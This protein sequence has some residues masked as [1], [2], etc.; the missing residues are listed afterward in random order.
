[1]ELDRRGKGL[2]VIEGSTFV[3]LGA[4]TVTFVVAAAIYRRRLRQWLTGAVFLGGFSWVF[5]HDPIRTL[6][7]LVLIQNFVAFPYWIGAAKPGAERRVAWAALSSM[8]VLTAVILMGGFDGLH[9]W[10]D[11][12]LNLGF[13]Q[14]ATQD[15]G[16]L[17][18]PGVRPSR[19]ASG[20]LSLRI[21]SEPALLRLA[22][23]D[24]RSIPLPS[25]PHYLSP[26][27]ET[28]GEGL[29]A[30]LGRFFLPPERRGL[31]LV[32]RVP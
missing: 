24:S 32:P 25:G 28:S 14:L 30:G 27:P 17:I 7:V 21:G 13:A 19:G 9:R 8:G 31:G 15:I 11:P 10:F 6:G 22:Q 12:S 18:L 1:M 5:V 4:T 2:R 23:G 29:R 3:E 20:L 16:R 26:E